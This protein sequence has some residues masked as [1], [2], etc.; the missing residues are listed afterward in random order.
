MKLQFYPSNPGM[1]PARVKPE[2]I[3]KNIQWV[4][5]DCESHGEVQTQAMN[6]TRK[7][8][9]ALSLPF[10]YDFYTKGV[11]LW[12]DLKHSIVILNFQSFAF[13]LLTT[14]TQC[15]TEIATCFRSILS[16]I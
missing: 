3:S 9:L 7:P 10:L 12:L 4:F 16:P 8:T 5:N 1:T 15:C 2:K 14:T 6:S 13:K 11:L